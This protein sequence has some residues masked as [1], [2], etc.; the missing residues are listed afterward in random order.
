MI[1]EFTVFSFNSVIFKLVKNPSDNTQIELSRNVVIKVCLGDKNANSDDD[2]LLATIWYYSQLDQEIVHRSYQF[3]NTISA[4]RFVDMVNAV[5]LFSQVDKL[6]GRTRGETAAELSMKPK[7]QVQIPSSPLSLDMAP[8]PLLDPVPE[9]EA[10][11]AFIDSAIKKSNVAIRAPP[12]PIRMFEK[13]VDNKEV[14]TWEPYPIRTNGIILAHELIDIVY[15]I[16]T[17]LSTLWMKNGSKSI[18]GF[19]RGGIKLASSSVYGARPIFGL[20]GAGDSKFS[21]S[22]AEDV[23]NYIYWLGYGITTNKSNVWVNFVFYIIITDSL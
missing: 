15:E 13:K 23:M 8:S 12:P 1:L 4:S 22:I 5:F 16:G 18:F 3:E 20:T 9:E 19:G 6:I 17:D 10:K 7:I 2:P 14:L 21:R 11:E